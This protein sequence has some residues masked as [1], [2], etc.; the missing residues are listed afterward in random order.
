M[1]DKRQD[2]E[3][4][5]AGRQSD[6]SSIEVLVLKRRGFGVVLATALLAVFSSIGC[7][8]FEFLTF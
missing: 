4:M 8:F 6:C 7:G 5:A 1:C 2:N 3:S